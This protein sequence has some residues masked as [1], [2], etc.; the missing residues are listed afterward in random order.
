M[1]FRAFTSENDE[2]NFECGRDWPHLRLQSLV[3]CF[4]VDSHNNDYRVLLRLRTIESSE[5]CIAF[6][7]TVLEVCTNAAF[8]I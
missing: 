3:I 1:T 7:P 2:G 8:K 6:E 5:T 4:V